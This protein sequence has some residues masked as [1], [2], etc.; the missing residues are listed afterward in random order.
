MSDGEARTRV[1]TI[2]GPAGV[3][4]STV[5]RTLAEDLGWAYLDTGAMYRLVTLA[6]LASG[7]ASDDEEALANTANELDADFTTDGRVLLGGADVT[8]RIRA[9]DVTARVADVASLRRVRRYVVAWQRG[10]AVRTGSVVAEGRDTGSVVFPDADVKI[11][12]DGDPEVRTRRRLAQEGREAD[13]RALAAAKRRIEERDRRDRERE[14]SPL[15]KPEGAWVLDTT[16]MTLDEVLAAV[17]SH[18][19]SRIPIDTGGGSPA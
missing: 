1:I 2:D 18:V 4:K 15:V 9:A 3:G 10:F 6:A 5:A 16:S 17:R 13:D 12:L 8:R 7:V 14:F 11:Y 19:R